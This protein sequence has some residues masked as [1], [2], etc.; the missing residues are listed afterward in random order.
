[1]EDSIH[2]IGKADVQTARDRS[3]AGTGGRVP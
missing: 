1:M 3:Q 2:G